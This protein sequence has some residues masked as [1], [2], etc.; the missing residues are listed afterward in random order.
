MNALP[1]TIG[2]AGFM[3]RARFV[4]VRAAAPTVMLFVIVVFPPIGR[5][6]VIEMVSGIA[7]G[8]A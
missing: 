8:L 6:T 2:V 1:A 4:N 7:V 5:V 3:G